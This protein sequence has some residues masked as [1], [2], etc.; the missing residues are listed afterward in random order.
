MPAALTAPAGAQGVDTEEYKA[1]FERC[2]IEQYGYSQ[3]A[4]DAYGG[5]FPFSYYG[6]ING[7][8]VCFAALEPR[9]WK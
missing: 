5:Q 7:Y 8:A 2:L 4:I 6:E 1:A 9:R 3:E